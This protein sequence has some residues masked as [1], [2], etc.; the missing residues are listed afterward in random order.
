[1]ED[2]LTGLREMLGPNVG[3]GLTDPRDPPTGLWPSEAAAMSR[4]VPKRRAEFAAGRRA[5]RAA[6]AD[7]NV[8]A[9]GIAQGRDRTP[10]WPTGLCGAIAHC[11]TCCIAIIAD[12]A[13]H[14]TLGVDVEPA[15]GLELDLTETVC[16]AYE[17]VWV[18]QQTDQRLAAKMIFCAKEAIYKAQYPLTQ[19]VI[20]FQAVTLEMAQE[21]FVFHGTAT[22]PKLKGMIMIRHDL[23]IATAYV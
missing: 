16:T 17:Q 2:I 9:T 23:I 1:M 19:K 10:Q 5:A 6:M 21:N 11:D 20:D 13:T 14:A 15:A 3:V 22:L 7:L 8:A 4:A 12:T 18:A